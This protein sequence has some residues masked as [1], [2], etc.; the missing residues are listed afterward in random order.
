MMKNLKNWHFARPELADAYLD[1]FDVGL[2]SAR[3]LFA[4]RRMGKTEFLK[5]DFIPAAE[6]KGYVV[7]Y[8][9]LWDLE[10]DP[11]TAL[12]SE[13]Y[14]TVEP[15]GFKKIWS[16]LKHPIH[17]KTIKASGRLL[18]LGEGIIEADLTETK[19]TT[20]TMLM[21]AMN[22]FDKKKYQMILV[23]DEAQV[24]AYEENSHFS[25]ALRAA[26]DIRKDRIKVIFAGSSETTLRRMFGVASEP[27]Y[28]WAPLEPFELLGGEFVVAMVQRVNSI[29]KFPLSECDAHE[30]FA[31]LKNT[32]EFFRRYIEHFLSNPDE[33]SKQALDF[34]KSQVF[35]DNNFKQQWETLLPADKII[36]S[37]IANAE[38]DLHGKLAI[39]KLGAALGIGSDVSK[40]TTHNALRRLS[41][42]NI[43]TKMGIGVY[44]L[45][46]EGFADWVKHIT[47]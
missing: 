20:G 2:I 11:A 15:K 34:T 25:H 17:L 26:L 18:G 30:S 46:D 24:L 47:I 29:S 4:R 6:K 41:M 43:I 14:K 22:Q 32:P 36:L 27:F 33:G 37:M 40:N 8:T 44:Q 35:D 19:R 5:K 16:G 45:E 42:K 10:I 39:Q 28:N 7:V 38:K 13:F 23:I 12:I 9:N 3:G 31:E 1:L 21:E